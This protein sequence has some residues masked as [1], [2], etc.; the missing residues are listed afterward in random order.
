MDENKKAYT[1][2][3]KEYTSKIRPYNDFYE[4]PNMINLIDDV[5]NK[6]V[7][8]AACGSGYYL[9]YLINKGAIVTGI[10]ISE[11]MINIAKETTNNKIRLFIHDLN[12]NLTFLNNEEFDLIISSLTLHYLKDWNNIL[13]EFHRILK[14]NGE[15]LIS[16]HHPFMDFTRFKCSNYFE[17]KLIN[18]SWSTSNDKINVQFYRRSLSEIINTLIKYRFIIDKIVEP[19]PIEKLK[20]YSLKDYNYLMN[21]PHFLIIKVKKV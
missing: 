9:E 13:K 19:Q 3:A 6:H 14:T 15:L 1:Q 21:N 12:D 18:D 20:D 5:K 2:L 16:T 8:D 7:L 4:R 11:E 17:L 10:D